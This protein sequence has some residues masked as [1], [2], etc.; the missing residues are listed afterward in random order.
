MRPQICVSTYC[1]R[2]LTGP[3]KLS[4]RGPDGTPASLTMGDKPAEISL[5]DL[6]AQIKAR[7]G[8]D[9]LE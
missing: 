4:Y 5:L 3:V 6:P 2:S 8:V 7:L 9:V 1:F